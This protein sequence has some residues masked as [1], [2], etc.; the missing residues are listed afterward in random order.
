MV[1]VPWEKEKIDFVPLRLGNGGGGELVVTTKD[2]TVSWYL[3]PH[4]DADYPYYQFNSPNYEY[5][6]IAME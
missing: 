2:F 6:Y 4:I 5:F 3:N 1:F